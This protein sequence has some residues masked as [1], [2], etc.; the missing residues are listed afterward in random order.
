MS[1]EIDDRI[2]R[3]QFDN[4]EFEK[5]AKTSISTLDKLKEK[6][7]FKNI[8]KGFMDINDGINQV[9]FAPITN[10][11][12]AVKAQFS[13]ME[14]AW[15]MVL[16][17][18]INNAISAGS[19]MVNALTID[20]VKTGFQEYET[21]MNA[22]QTIWANT[23]DKGTSM[24]EITAA[25]NELNKYADQT[26]YNFTQMTSNI[27]RFT[28]AGVDLKTS[29]K[30]IKGISNLAAVSGASAEDASRAMYQLS[31]AISSGTIKLM[32]WNSVVNA[33]MGGEGFQNVLKET[34]RE[35]G[36][37]ID[38]IIKKAGSFRESLSKNWLTSEILIKSLEKYTDT[39]TELGKTATEAATKV[40]TFT[41]LWDTLKESVQSGW[42][43]SWRLI[44]GDFEEAR[45]VFTKLSDALQGFLSP[46][47]EA[48][49]SVLAA[50]AGIG[51]ESEK[52]SE[53]IGEV[54][55][56]LNE[57][58]EIAMRVIR[59][60]YKNGVEIRFPLLEAD[61]Y[62]AK[63]VQQRV[64]EIIYGVEKASANAEK[65]VTKP[66]VDP[67]SGLTGREMVIEGLKAALQ[68]LAFSIN[69]VREA[70]QD[71]F[72]PMTAEKLIE[73]SR[74]FMEFNQKTW[75]TSEAAD[76]LKRT[77]RGIFSI[78]SILIKSVKNTIKVIV[79]I[80]SAIDPL[81]SGI[82]EVTGSI[83]DFIY[84]LDKGV[85]TGSFFVDAV[86]YIIEHISKLPGIMRDLVVSIGD[87]VGID[88]EKIFSKVSDGANTAFDTIKDAAES[89]KKDPVQ[90]I[91]DF[92]E[93]AREKFKPLEW[94]GT[95]FKNLWEGI[96]N[97]VSNI[98]KGVKWV[99]DGIVNLFS[100]ISNPFSDLTFEDVFDASKLFAVGSFG[101]AMV[102]ITTFVLDLKKTF[103]D[104]GL[105]G[106]FGSI[107][108][109]FDSVGGVIVSFQNSI[110]A[111][112]LL[113]IAIAIA[114]L[115][116]SMI[117][118]S[119]IKQEPLRNAMFAIGELF[120]GI[121]LSLRTLNSVEI[122]ALGGALTGLALA[123]ASLTGSILL[124]GMFSSDTVSQGLST[125]LIL[126][127]SIAG[128]IKLMTGAGGLA[129][130]KNVTILFGVGSAIRSFAAAIS[131]LIIP[132]ITLS[133]LSEKV[134][135]WNG[136][137]V[138]A[139]TI[140]VL[141]SALSILAMVFA[142]MDITKMP[143]I[144]MSLIGFASA[145]QMITA[146]LIT[147]NAI[148]PFYL[149]ESLMALGV[150]MGGLVVS[151]LALA[152]ASKFGGKGFIGVVIGI[153]SLVGA[154]T[155]LLPQVAALTLINQ[156]KLTNVAKS[157]SMIIVAFSA[158]LAIA[159][160]FG[161][162]LAILVGAITALTLASAI[163]ISSVVSLLRA[164]TDFANADL[165]GIK[166]RL[167]EACDAIIFNAPKMRE[168]FVAM[169]KEG[170]K[171][172]EETYPDAFDTIG[173]FISDL[174]DEIATRIEEY[175]AKI[176]DIAV[177]IIK[178]LLSGLSE[179][180]E[181]LAL[182]IVDF[183]I[184][185]TNALSNAVETR[186]DEIIEAIGNLVNA[187]L[188]MLGK[189]VPKLMETIKG[190]VSEI[191]EGLT[192]GLDNATGEFKL[193]TFISALFDTSG[194]PALISAIW[195]FVSDV[196]SGFA[197]GWEE[198]VANLGPS[199]EKLIENL[200]NYIKEDSPVARIGG[201]ILGEIWLSIENAINDV[202]NIKPFELAKKLVGLLIDPLR[203]VN[204]IS[205]LWDAG[206]NLVGDIVKG[207]HPGLY[208]VGDTIKKIG[209][210]PR[211]WL[212]D[213]Q[214]KIKEI[215]I[216]IIDGIIEGIKEA[217]EDLKTT[218][219]EIIEWIPN[220]IK[221]KLGIN[222]PSKV[223][224]PLGSS[225]S[226]GL[227]VGV[228]KASGLVDDSI[229]T[230]SDDMY[231]SLAK[232]MSD[233]NDVIYT[234]VDYQPE[235]K[236]VLNLDDVTRNAGYLNGMFTNQE[237]ALRQLGASMSTNV[238]FDDIQNGR[239]DGSNVVSEIQSLRSDVNKLN[240]SISNMR[241]V[242]DSGALVG[243][244]AGPMDSALGRRSVYSR[245]GV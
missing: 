196:F 39:T 102:S 110:R 84:W 36:V 56:E 166:E 106:I 161:K 111:N 24:E 179:N 133:V 32:D 242:M 45:S 94:V 127:F 59:G 145:I 108:G 162:Q 41:Q 124:L 1:R 155:L 42:S 21:Q 220:N 231:K 174:L 181:E 217:F 4:K 100:N 44:I 83:G 156:K 29:V 210:K 209:D 48:R 72:P 99:K 105:L 169:I 191:R 27:G 115:A 239:Y 11:I 221:D 112:I 131:A 46:F 139:G 31:Q 167:S 98:I 182:Y 33:N 35:H 2:V 91:E 14:M 75:L 238:S 123:V 160:V 92:T 62:D 128:A 103:G 237:I 141:T 12:D 190:V 109:V 229:N 65:A 207:I 67:L 227:A 82:L 69:L 132:L 234:D 178:G 16:A 138:I 53:S 177:S 233:M 241:I 22:I 222:S 66:V 17:N 219:N 71:V 120:A 197:D 78:F 163:F 19:K 101:A 175:T 223:M 225:V 185:V 168:A 10:G 212:V 152:V 143:G 213:I 142:T 107:K 149:G 93:L 63:A 208:R 96:K 68:R 20:P 180:S 140:A 195:S 236:P 54:N 43:E 73:L 224:I 193:G 30:A 74:K 80:F 49:N 202:T 176:V 70:F 119:A 154:I 64:N 114:I 186:S 18:M 55:K 57:L 3:L 76:G 136:F 26:I 130:G 173:D 47:A 211:E 104:K 165:T 37:A 81:N 129:G 218:V 85:L 89:L 183:V 15:S 50:W 203:G 200:I 153:S 7:Q 188:V 8:K 157:L 122:V 205:A 159:G 214:D 172:F 113:K 97:V 86:D 204:I 164:I 148:D 215:G 189:A 244:I 235:I 9:K 60:D 147:I 228:E 88:F 38:A 40:K 58:D 87:F 170:L 77:L 226:E 118:I 90:S 95:F 232:T 171:A 187:I 230:M 23:K 79:K 117:A 25:L 34:A 198:G 13:S 144:F 184:A 206:W 245:R 146:A 28:A 243:S 199:V 135:I 126:L 116:A 137:W 194:I 125:I 51:T 151:M 240:E 61:G 6:L 121:I 216:G 5:H 158:G 134:N 201:A 52:T 192:A 150:I